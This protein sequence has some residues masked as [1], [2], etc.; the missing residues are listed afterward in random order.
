MRVP[1]ATAEVY[2]KPGVSVP[3][4]MR[5]DSKHRNVGF[6][7]LS[8]RCTVTSLTTAPSQKR[9][10]GP[11]LNRIFLCVF[12]ADHFGAG[13]GPSDGAAVTYTSRAVLPSCLVDRKGSRRRLDSL[14]GY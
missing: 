13:H 5:V 4:E 12:R 1:V 7:A 3:L 11:S 10:F 9:T 2:R 14:I 6:L 8:G